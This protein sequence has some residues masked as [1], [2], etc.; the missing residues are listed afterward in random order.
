M[1]LIIIQCFPFFPMFTTEFVC[2]VL[3]HSRKLLDTI[4]DATFKGNSFIPFL[5][6][7]SD[8]PSLFI[9]YLAAFAQ[10]DHQLP[11]IFMSC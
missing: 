3:P 1:K 10:S 7:C 2:T 9:N 6:E 8:I 11:S 4:F 5:S